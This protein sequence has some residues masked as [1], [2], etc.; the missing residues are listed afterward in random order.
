MFVN[1]TVP[2]SPLRRA[3]QAFEITAPDASVSV[4]VQPLM[5]AGPVVTLTVATNPPCHW[6]SDETTA[7]HRPGVPGLDDDVLGRGDD[8]LGAGDG[9][10][11]RNTSASGGYQR[12][13]IFWMPV[14]PFGC[15]PSVV[16]A[17]VLNPVHWSTTVIGDWAVLRPLAQPGWRC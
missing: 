4:T 11:P 15:T 14:V 13:D 6:L 5:A 2:V 10:T 16:S 1:R 8:V 3:F 17:D 9:I 12:S 7:V